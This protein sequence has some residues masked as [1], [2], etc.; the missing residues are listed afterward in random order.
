MNKFKVGDKVICKNDYKS[1]FLGIG[2]EYTVSSAD[3]DYLTVEGSQMVYDAERFELAPTQTPQKHQKEIIAWANGATIQYWS[4]HFEEWIDVSNHRPTW[5]SY[6]KYRVKPDKSDEIEAEVAKLYEEIDK[7]RKAI[8]DLEGL[9]VKLYS[10][11]EQ[12]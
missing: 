6:L 1:L 2:R 9:I 5:I 4:K 8:A 11:G 10:S 12:L 7:N 3:N